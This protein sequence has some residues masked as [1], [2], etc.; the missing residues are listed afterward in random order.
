MPQAAAPPISPILTTLKAA[1]RNLLLL[2]LIAVVSR[3]TTNPTPETTNQDRVT[4][5]AIRTKEV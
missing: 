3:S 1:H 4:T 5:V 2:T